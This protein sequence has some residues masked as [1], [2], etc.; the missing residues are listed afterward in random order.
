MTSFGVW[1]NLRLFQFLHSP[2]RFWT[3]ARWQTKASL[4]QLYQISGKASQWGDRAAGNIV[5]MWD[6]SHSYLHTPVILHQVRLTLQGWSY[7]GNLTIQVIEGN[8]VNHLDMFLPCMVGVLVFIGFHY[9]HYWGWWRSC[10][11]LGVGVWWGGVLCLWS[12]K[13]R[14]LRTG[15]E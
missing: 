2:P 9:T 3:S 8:L 7:F 10:R 6:W 15:N 1:A 12:L 4:E 14:S 5:K 11:G 13:E